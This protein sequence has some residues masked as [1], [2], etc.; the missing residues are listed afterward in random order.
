[1]GRR[2][3]KGKPCGATCIERKDN[4]L[5]DAGIRVA[6]S[7]SSTRDL[8]ENRKSA[9]YTLSP[10]VKGK[11]Y[12]ST[13]LAQKNTKQILQNLQDEGSIRKIDGLV[14]E[15]DINWRAALSDGTNFVGGGMY[16]SFVS[17]RYKK[18]L[19]DAVN[20]Y[21]PSGVK[22]GRI[23]Q[24]EVEALKIAGDNGIGPKL[25]GARLS[26]RAE[27]DDYGISYRGAIA[28]SKVGA[29]TYDKAGENWGNFG[30]KSDLLW[31]SAAALHRLGVAHNDMHGGNI[32]MSADGKAY[33]VDFGLAQ[34]SFKAALAEAVGSINDSNWQFRGS[35]DRGHGATA[36]DN[37][38]NV[39]FF[40]TKKGFHPEEIDEMF[41][42]GIRS[43]DNSYKEGV[44]GRLSDKD[45]KK[46]I[47]IFYEG[48]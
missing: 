37:L 42:T 1:M 2:C 48:I 11:E 15:K 13:T 25:L 28:M 4:C 3:Q 17:V 21:L 29:V 18:L 14:K 43:S 30:S 22:T 19:G 35:K 8:V 6:N 32:R 44:W 20:D 33:F 41:E 39:R 7:L 23:G 36:R 16:G 47:E 31:E 10:S 24:H 27:S 45:A 9:P 38:W 26:N 12:S 46:A 40:L 5:K 34:V